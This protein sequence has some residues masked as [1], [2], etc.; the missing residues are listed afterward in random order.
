MAEHE[1]PEQL[2]R[3]TFVRSM[4]GIALWIAASFIFVILAG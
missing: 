1:T 2:A 3:Q 4:I